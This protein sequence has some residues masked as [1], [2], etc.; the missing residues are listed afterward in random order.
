[1]PLP[2]LWLTTLISRYSATTCPL[3]ILIF[4]VPKQDSRFSAPIPVLYKIH[5][6]EALV[7]WDPVSRAPALAAQQQ[8]PVEQVAARAVSSETPAAQ[9]RSL[10]AL[11]L[12]SAGRSV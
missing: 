9:A 8:V 2:S 4:S 5:P 10:I 7:A 6:V 12:S 11:I 1:M 3:L